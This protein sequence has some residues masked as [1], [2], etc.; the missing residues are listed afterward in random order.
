M[1]TY[2]IRNLRLT[3]Y[4]RPPST[5]NVR[6]TFSLCA[7]GAPSLRANTREEV[8]KE[9][10]EREGCH[11]EIRVSEETVRENNHQISFNYKQDGGRA[12]KSGLTPT[13]AT[14]HS[15]LGEMFS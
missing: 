2:G 3:E 5:F 13:T 1:W 11:A 4:N 9:G 12:M 10:D 7:S 15:S 8:E 6:L 14:T